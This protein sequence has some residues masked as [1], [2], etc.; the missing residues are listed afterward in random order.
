L[1]KG[2][3]PFTSTA[4]KKASKQSLPGRFYA[5]GFYFNLLPM[6]NQ[7]RR[8]DQVKSSEKLFFWSAVLLLVTLLVL[9]F[10]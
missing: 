5:L 10:I 2:S 4:L 8:P 3:T 7:G 1:D 9:K 6:E